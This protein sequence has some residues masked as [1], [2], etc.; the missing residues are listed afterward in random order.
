MITSRDQ[1]ILNVI[2]EFHVL[3][4]SQISRLFFPSP[5]YARK[6]LKYLTDS[7]FIKRTRS[8]IDSSFAYYL[9]KKSLLQQ[10]HHDLIRAEIYVS[11]SKLYEVLEWHNEFTIGHIRPDALAYVRNKG[12]VHPVIVEVHL[13]KQFDFEKYRADLYPYFGVRPYVII[14]S[15]K[16]KNVPATQKFKQVCLDMSGLDA[17][18]R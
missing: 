5:Q 12:I 15:E 1:E 9:D 4:I 18:F 16:L 7:G 2:D 14:C 13:S 11:M 8:T 17:L 6:R 3:T 10:I